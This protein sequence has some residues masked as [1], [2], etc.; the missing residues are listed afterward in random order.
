MSKDS[1]PTDALVFPKAS[2]KCLAVIGG[3]AS[4]FLGKSKSY[5]LSA[6]FS[7][8]PQGAHFSLPSTITFLKWVD[9]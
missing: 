4:P 7:C 5:F 8:S 2:K 9:A 6:P 1:Y 3:I